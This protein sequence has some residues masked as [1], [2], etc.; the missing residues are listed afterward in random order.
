MELVGVRLENVGGFQAAEFDMKGNRLLIGENNSGKTSLLRIC[1]WLFNVADAALLSGRRRLSEN[2]RLLLVPARA[3][4]NKAR[5]LILRIFIP[6]GRAGR[7]FNA[8]NGVCE[9]RIQFRSEVTYARI[10]VPRRGEGSE[11]EEKAIDLFRR[12]Q[13]SY[14]ALYVGAA[15]DARSH[16]FRSSLKTALTQSLSGA[17]IGSG[18]GRMSTLGKNFTENARELSRAGEGQA[19]LVWESTR[20]YLR[21]LFD[22]DANF[23]LDINPQTMIEFL[24]SQIE[25]AFSMGEHDAQRV[26]I[27]Q[28]GAGTQSVMAMALIQLSM[29]GAEKRLLLLEEPEAFL[30]PSAQRTIAWQIFRK[31][32]V[33]IMAT[34]HSSLVLAEAAPADV[35]VLREHM[36]YPAGVV[37]NDQE[38]KDHYQL[39]TWASGSMFDRSLLLVEGPGDLAF[40]EAMR[41]NL[42]GI[43]PIPV[44]SRMRVAAVGGKNSFGPWLRL[45]RRYR[46]PN[47][48]SL[49]Y[50]VLVC[51]DSVDASSAIL[52]AIRENDITVQADVQAKF[53]DIMGE[54]D[55]GSL[56][57]EDAN[58]VARR[59]GSANLSIV[60]KDFPVHLMPVD[61]E[62]TLTVELSDCRAIK[63]ADLMNIEAQSAGVLAARLGSKGGEGKASEK[64]GAKAPHVRSKLACYLNW[65][66]VSS[67]LKLLIWRW[68]QPAVSGSSLS[69]PIELQ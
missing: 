51:V 35:V 26:P 27:D 12:L 39:S 50:S 23:G 63:F 24:V 14:C 45:L 67:D 48:R 38:E 7:R 1:D 9:L 40:F 3:T 53:S 58:L 28:L 16:L 18:L 29:A 36:I 55:A 47:S 64:S 4:R 65:N 60:E 62:Y 6:D 43:V 33:Q 11:S 61:L 41:R 17:L 57:R 13:G 8:V 22:L 15:R 25:P 30:H 37:D 59:T 10:T 42:E 44:L 49:A 52:R 54:F 19:N 2:E 5:R 32:D 21:G 46:E 69:R 20:E 66:E 31:S 34:T 56:T 68:I